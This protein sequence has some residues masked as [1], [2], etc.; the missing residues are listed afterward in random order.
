MNK[1]IAKKIM[2]RYLL[3]WRLYAYQVSWVDRVRMEYIRSGIMPP[4]AIP[5]RTLGPAKDRRRV[6]LNYTDRQYK[7][8]KRKIFR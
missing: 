8:A 1:R 3:P 5:L 7:A 2:N 4:L 6:K